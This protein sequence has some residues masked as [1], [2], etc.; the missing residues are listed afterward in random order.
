M[1]GGVAVLQEV[2]KD[3]KEPLAGA[4]DQYSLPPPK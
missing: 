1:A 4:L 2:N 3:E